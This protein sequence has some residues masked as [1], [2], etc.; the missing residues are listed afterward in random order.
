LSTLIGDLVLFRRGAVVRRL[1]L[2]G[3]L[4][5]LLALVAPQWTR[6]DT[7]VLV[8]GHALAA[9]EVAFTRTFCG[10]GS[11]FP[12]LYRVP[13]HVRDHPE[14]RFIPLQQVA[15]ELAGS[16]KQYCDANNIRFVNNENSLTTLMYWLLWSR[17]DMSLVD[18]G[19]SLH[20]IRLAGLA[21]FAAVA[22]WA[23]LSVGAATL[24]VLLAIDGMHD[25]V[26]MSY[27]LYPFLAPMVLVAA[28]FYA[29]SMRWLAG[30]RWW[31]LALV[32]LVSGMYT[33]FAANLRTSYL[34]VMLAMSAVV[35]LEAVGRWRFQS[36]LQW[37][38]CTRRVAAVAVIFASGYAALQYG[39]ITRHLPKEVVAAAPHHTVA[40]PL[41]LSLGVPESELSSREGIRW[42]DRAGL[43]L[44][45]RMIPD[46]TYL[47]PEYDRALFMYYRHLWT[48]YPGEMLHLYW[49]KFSMAG[50]NIVTSIR[51][52]AGLDGLLIRYLLWPQSL[53]QNGLLLLA[54]WC[55]LCVGG[56][57]AAVRRQ[58]S[59]GSLVALLSVGAVLLLIESAI[60]MPI[61]ALPYHGYLV[62]YLEFTS[63][64]ALQ[65]VFALIWQRRQSAASSPAR[66][67]SNYF[68]AISDDFQ[69]RMNPFDLRARLE[70]FDGEFRQL[71]LK[72]ALVLDVGA[73][74]G[75]F[76]LAAQRHGAQ[77]VPL[78]IAPRLVRRVRQS[79]PAAL[80][81]S[82]TQ[83]PFSPATFDVVISSECIEHTAD[84]EAAVREMLRVLRPG[85][86]VL[87]T[88]PNLLW[89]WSIAIAEAIG[90]RRFEGIENWLS[91]RALKRAI[92]DG[93][94][95][96][97]RTAGLHILPFQL[98]VL[99]P[100]LRF[101]NSKGQWARG[102]M[103]NQCWVARR[104]PPTAS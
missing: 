40:H 24:L 37:S 51:D 54:V 43:A 59:L 88:T 57:W 73:G 38:D 98:D 83:L 1:S 8:D 42:E 71:P 16:I 69:E 27:S 103:I 14:M 64:L 67:T 84:P 80:C 45:Q 97:V 70:W 33:A 52:D 95:I 76:S 93:G 22:V 12:A 31:Q 96:I 46:A 36:G 17:P 21:L 77:V 91:R 101:M 7:P 29:G 82:A 25:I 35:M 87:L 11:S 6:V 28:A 86:F 63:V 75:Q 99:H 58:S 9:L 104:V 55:S 15:V 2:L 30:G 53:V 89:R 68:D 92:E 20:R 47:G 72:G 81:G 85:G 49:R 94:A 102:V 61:H 39:T 41:V 50:I 78:D 44:A 56:L 65:G 34:P 100:L 60:I 79:F 26:D 3:A 66:K 19:T 90:I 23:G 5:L 13:H 32:T 62:W 18:L 74:L 10:T 48:A 4:L